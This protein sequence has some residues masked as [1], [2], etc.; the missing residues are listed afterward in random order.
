MSDVTDV[1][2]LPVD[3][4]DG[5]P[6]SAGMPYTAKPVD[7]KIL[8]QFVSGV[9]NAINSGAMRLPSRDIPQTIAQDPHA[10]N[11][12]YIPPAKMS[13]DYVQQYNHM[14]TNPN[15]PLPQKENTSMVDNVYNEL[16]LPI[17]LTVLYFLFQLP[18]FHRFFH[19]HMGFL[20][21]EDGNYNLNGYIFVSTLFGIIVHAFIKIHGYLSGL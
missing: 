21:G 20:F 11:P 18:F 14:K 15:V 10:S 3:A 16:Q 17:L 5:L 4:V 9:Q 13:V 8:Q 19:T 6:P 12:N 1:N 2:S 7:E